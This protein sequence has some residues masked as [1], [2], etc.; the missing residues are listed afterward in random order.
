MNSELLLNRA[1]ELARKAHEGQFDKVGARYSALHRRSLLAL[2][3]PYM[4]HPIQ[5]TNS[6]ATIDEKIVGVLH[7]AIEDS[8]LSFDT[9]KELGFIDVFPD[10][11]R[12]RER[13]AKI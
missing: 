12:R 1:I 13:Q 7:D 8:D 10:R 6:L 5:V 9:L 4:G 11:S 3:Q 2:R